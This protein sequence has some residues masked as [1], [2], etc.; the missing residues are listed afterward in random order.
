MLAYALGTPVLATR[1]GGMPEAIIHGETAIT[2]PPNDP[3]MLADGLS[4]AL[5][6]PLKLREMGERGRAYA[7]REFSWDLVAKQH[8]DLY[9]EATRARGNP[10]SE[11]N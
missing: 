6:E 8:V 10:I 2:I 1:T 4:I 9:E 7:S 11:R 3:Q 5:K